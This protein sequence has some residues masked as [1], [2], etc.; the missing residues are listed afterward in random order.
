MPPLILAGARVFVAAGVAFAAATQGFHEILGSGEDLQFGRV[1]LLLFIFDPA[2]I[3]PKPAARTERIFYDGHCGLCHRAVR[4]VLAEDRAGD[5]FRF[6]PLAGD[7]FRA[8]VPEGARAG[9]PDSI[10]LRRA[11][12]GLLTRSAAVLYIGARLGGAWRILAAVTWI[13][14]RPLRDL[15]YDGVARVRYRLFG[16]PAEVCPIIP[17]ALRGRFDA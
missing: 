5:A 17:P 10:V 6:A 3:A 2:W 7:A 9:L 14:P 13:I 11:D 4:F 12:G 1:L 15:A 8:A 16:R